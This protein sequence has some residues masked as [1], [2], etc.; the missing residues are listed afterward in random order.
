MP[1][2]RGFT[3][4]LVNAPPDTLK[5]TIFAG[6]IQQKL[7]PSSKI[8]DDEFIEVIVGLQHEFRHAEQMSKDC[9]KDTKYG[10]QLALSQLAILGNEDFT[11]DQYPNILHEIDAEQHAIKNT[12]SYLKASFPDK[13][14]DRILL[15][16]LNDRIAKGLSPHFKKDHKPFESM[17]EIIQA[18]QD[19][20]DHYDEHPKFY[21]PGHIQQ[22]SD[23]EFLNALEHMS[24]SGAIGPF[25]RKFKGEHSNYEIDKLMA[26]MTEHI[27]PGIKNRF[28]SLKTADLSITT[29]Y[30]QPFPDDT[31]ATINKI[32]RLRKQNAENRKLHRFKS[33][34]KI[35]NISDLD[36]AAAEITTSQSQTQGGPGTMLTKKNSYCFEC[37]RT[38]PHA[39]VGKKSPF[40]GTGPARA[41]LAITS[42][43]MSETTWSDKYW[44]CEHCGHI[45][46]NA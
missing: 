22:Y 26:A 23:D 9:Q 28:A 27:H 15:N 33:Q 40:E 12:R 24:L 1:K 17:D 20:I 16:I 3:A 42:L 10:R 6:N 37:E 21:A 13:D 36:A 25:T 11:D 29:V 18:F 35:R 34:S 14:T 8:Q 4:H 30:G 31:R 2:G 5:I 38:T 45:K 41:I 39:Y 46:K 43:G 44:Q 7:L 19:K 32:N